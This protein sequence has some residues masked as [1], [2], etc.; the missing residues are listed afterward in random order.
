MNLS[1]ISDV[2]IVGGG[3]IGL[4]IARRLRKK[5]AANI[6]VLE[7]GAVGREASYAAAGMLAPQAE[8]DEANDFFDLCRRSS[9]LYPS[10]AAELFD[11]TGIDIELD[12]S[13]TL[14]L[15][16]TDADV[17]EIRRRFAWQK[18]AHLEIEHLSAE[19]TRK[20]EPFA[21]PDVR[22]ALFFP[23]DWQVENR[24]LLA[25]LEKFARTN[26]IEI[27]EN[28]EVKNILIERGKVAGAETADGKFSASAVV[29]ATGAWTS[30]IKAGGFS[31]P[32]VA[33]IRGQMASFKTA[34]RLFKRVI[35]SP[36]G[37]LVPRADGRILAGATV[38]SVGFDKSVTTSGID[39]LRENAFEIA[40]SLV[41][42][43]PSETWANLR[44]WAADGFPVLGAFPEAENLFIAT[45]H[46]RNGILLAPATAEILAAKIVANV[47]SNY[48]NIYSPRRFRTAQAV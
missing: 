23:N 27:V 37:Y 22:E 15:A 32:P 44:P 8:C 4:A 36:R 19:Q 17:R 9:G 46:Y 31:L 26:R 21:S 18:K 7:R 40:P 2:L 13:G 34:K 45:A 43:K 47:E 3:V 42:L 33:P 5:A 10:F 6:T 12:C 29:L 28:A 41:N 1:K 30:F 39:F 16:F 25:A 11:E 35:Y 38:E 48:L 24:K 20:L 14:Y